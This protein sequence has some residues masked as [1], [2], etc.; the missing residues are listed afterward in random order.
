MRQPCM[1]M[2]AK[3]NASTTTTTHKG[4]VTVT[5]VETSSR[6]TLQSHTPQKSPTPPNP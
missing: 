4:N 1:A 6:N 5:M 3:P 2:S